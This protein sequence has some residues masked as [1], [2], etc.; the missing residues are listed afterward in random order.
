MQACSEPPPCVAVQSAKLSFAFV[1]HIRS[2][3]FVGRLLASVCL[4]RLLETEGPPDVK[5]DQPTRNLSPT[6]T[7]LS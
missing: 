2:D 6:H 5:A 4:C 3:A 1:T 7:L